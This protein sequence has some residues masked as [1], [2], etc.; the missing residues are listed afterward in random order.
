MASKD[1]PPVEVLR[2]L[3][4]YDPDTGKLYWRP[5][6]AEMFAS[7]RAAGVFNTRHAGAEA[8]T[9]DDGSGYRQGAILYYSCRAHRV[10]WAMQTGS[11]PSMK[12]DHIDGNR[13]NNAWA[14]LRLATDIENGRNTASRKGATSRF[15]GVGWHSQMRVWRAYISADGKVK[16][17]G[18][19]DDEVSAALAYDKAAREMFGQFAKPNFPL[20]PS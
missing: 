8:F 15:L 18:C 6:P 4:R 3:L 16:H 17:L 19:F 1:L 7:P 5:R 20:H 12:I 2:Q 10:I 11:W 9:S 14:N 13:Q